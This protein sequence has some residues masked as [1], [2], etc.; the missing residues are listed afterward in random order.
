MAFAT[1]L[2]KMKDKFSPTW[3]EDELEEYVRKKIKEEIEDYYS[4]QIELLSIEDNFIEVWVFISALLENS[5]LK[6]MVKWL[7]EHIKED[8]LTVEDFEIREI[9]NF[10]DLYDDNKP[11]LFIHL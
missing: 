4:T 9:V 6:E 2:I 7:E 11:I 3:T 5:Y 10:N 8:G 1:H